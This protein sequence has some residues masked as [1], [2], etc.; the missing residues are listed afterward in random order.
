MKYLKSIEADPHKRN[1]FQRKP[2][3]LTESGNPYEL[4]K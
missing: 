3:C 2:H 1:L 4:V